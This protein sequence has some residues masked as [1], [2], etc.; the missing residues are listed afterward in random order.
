MRISTFLLF[1]TILPLLGALGHDLYLAYG[2]DQ[3]FS[4]LPKFSDLGYLWVT[5]HADSFQMARQSID[6]ESWA[7]LISPILELPSV[8]VTAILPGI[9][10]AVMLGIRAKNILMERGFS[11]KAGGFV[12]R[13]GLEKKG[14]KFNYKRK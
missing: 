1:I 3:D 5:Y 12:F 11:R 13:G 9:I 4:K 6:P 2:E 7:A 14:G 10:I 8:L